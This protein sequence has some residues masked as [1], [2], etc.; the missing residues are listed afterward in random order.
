MTLEDFV[1]DKNNCF[2]DKRY[3]DNTRGVLLL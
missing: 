1:H 3:V 2:T